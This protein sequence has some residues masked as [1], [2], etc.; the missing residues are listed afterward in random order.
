M[1]PNTQQTALWIPE[2]DPPLTFNPCHQGR[3]LSS[4]TVFVGLEFQMHR[5]R[6]SPVG[7]GSDPEQVDAP[8]EQIGL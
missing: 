6:E 1:S 8:V 3:Y 7:V 4:L 2:L 5:L